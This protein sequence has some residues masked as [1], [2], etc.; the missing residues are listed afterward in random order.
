MRKISV[1]FTAL[2]LLGLSGRGNT[3]GDRALSGA[4]I[5]AAAGGAIGAATTSSQVDLGQ[6][7]WRQD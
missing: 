1:V 4:G 2:S 7:V 5:G 3:P 6:P